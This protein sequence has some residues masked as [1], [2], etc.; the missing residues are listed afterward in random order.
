MIK[1]IRIVIQK[2]DLKSRA[3]AH[4]AK[5]NNMGELIPVSGSPMY[6]PF[7]LIHYFLRNKCPDAVVF[8]YLNDYQSFFRTILRF[9]SELL[10]IVIARITAISI[11]WICHNIDKESSSYYPK[12][13][14]A[15]RS[16]LIKFADKIFVMDELLVDPC[17]YTL[18]VPAN[19]IESICF[20]R[21][22]VLGLDNMAKSRST[23]QF[24]QKVHSWSYY[25]KR[26]KGEALIGL[27]IGN[28]LDKFLDGLQVLGKVSKYSEIGGKEIAFIV[29]G[30]IGRWL[31]QRDPETYEILNKSN[32]VL[33]IDKYMEFQAVR[34]N[35]VCDFVWKPNADLSV[36]LTAY[37]ASLAGLPVVAFMGTFFGDFIT[38]YRLGFA[39]N[40]DN[41]FTTDLMNRLQEWNTKNSFLFL[42]SK[43]WDYGAKLIF[44]A[45]LKKTRLSRKPK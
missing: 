42:K 7:V 15:R 20:G 4:S 12:L 38:Y 17:R 35:E 21:T 13:T 26:K 36:N 9:S 31:K 27:W 28:A 45:A 6:L 40:R 39:V 34:W 22:D 18:Q 43:T 24:I 5:R 10:T 8:R 3:W 33:M 1:K 19:K 32:K 41:P 2:N 11:L 14:G 16:I 25:K 23:E 44:R 29:I 30:P 37:N